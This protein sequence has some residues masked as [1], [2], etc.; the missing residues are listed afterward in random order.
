MNGLLFCNFTHT[1][2]CSLTF[3]INTFKGFTIFSQYWVIM[4]L[5]H[6][7][8]FKPQTLTIKL[9]S[10]YHWFRILTEQNDCLILRNMYMKEP[11]Q[12][13]F[14]CVSVQSDPRS[15]TGNMAQSVNCTLAHSCPK[16]WSNGT[17]Y[18]YIILAVATKSVCKTAFSESHLRGRPQLS[19]YAGCMWGY[20][21]V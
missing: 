16:V 14:I 12:R 19:V 10:K 17:Q 8:P 1:H 21:E 4:I 13:W 9:M 20:R 2:N 18:H 15:S 5:N 7:I 11:Q 3:Q 6:N